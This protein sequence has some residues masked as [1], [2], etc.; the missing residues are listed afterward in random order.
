M[1]HRTERLSVTRNRCN[2]L[3]LMPLDTLRIEYSL[4]TTHLMK[5]VK[6]LNI[7]ICRTGVSCLFTALCLQ[8]SCLQLA[9]CGPRQKYYQI[10]LACWASSLQAQQDWVPQDWSG[11][12]LVQASRGSSSVQIAHGLWG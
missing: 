9:Y 12:L 8:S 1:H 7:Y 5:S 3:I 6:P 2:P 11:T 4:H 10:S